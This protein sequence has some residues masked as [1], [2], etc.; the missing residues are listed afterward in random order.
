MC[1][2][3]SAVSLVGPLLFTSCP[4]AT[5]MAVNTVPDALRQEGEEKFTFFKQSLLEF[6][7]RSF[8]HKRKGITSSTQK[9]VIDVTEV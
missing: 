3:Y 2:F 8:T 6:V 7:C 9:A 5:S 4:V 1:L